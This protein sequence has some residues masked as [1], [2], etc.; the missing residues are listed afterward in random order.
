MRYEIKGDAGWITFDRP[1]AANSLPIEEME[2]LVD[3]LERGEEERAV[4]LY[5]EGGVFSAGGDLSE[6]AEVDG[7]EDAERFASALVDSIH[8]VERLDVPVIAAVD[9]ACYGAGFELVVASD[10]AVAGRGASF[11]LPETEI[12]V[13]APHTVERVASV[14]GRKRT[15]ELAMLGGPVDA[16]TALDW[17][18]V[19]RVVDECTTDEAAADLAGELAEL[20]RRAL[21]TTKRRIRARLE[22]PGEDE[23]T[24]RTMAYHLTTEET[25][26]RIEEATD[27]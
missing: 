26:S 12:G 10:L 7:P 11:G 23:V 25:Q 20:D 18:V 17:G 14:A 4:V 19:N 9:G 16:E 3:L 27:D 13:F 24:E 21:R 15:T 22:S 8:A 2:E 1:E 5:G 6:L